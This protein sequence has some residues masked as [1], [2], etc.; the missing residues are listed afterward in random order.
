MDALGY[1]L[2]PCW[3]RKNDSVLY[4]ADSVLDSSFLGGVAVKPCLLFLGLFVKSI[5]VRKGY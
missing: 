1:W 5:L 3:C 4:Q 2:A